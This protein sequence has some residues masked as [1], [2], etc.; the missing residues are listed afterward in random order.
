VPPAIAYRLLEYALWAYALLLPL[1][2]LYF[3]PA[4][5]SRLQLTEL[6]FLLAA[7]LALWVYR[8]RLLTALASPPVVALL[9]YLFVLSLATFSGASPA[10]YP[11]LLGRFYLLGVLLVFATYVADLGAPGQRKVI[12]AWTAGLY[13]MG[14]LAYLGY[15]LALAGYPTPLVSYY[16]NYP[17]FGTL[18]R[19]VGSAGGATAL[20]ALALL[21]LTVAYLRWR[22]TGARPWLLIFFAPLLLL[23]FSKEVLLLLLAL[24]LVE[25]LLQSRRGLR[26]VVVLSLSLLYLL[27]TH[28]LVEPVGDHSPRQS[29]RVYT[30]GR[31][32]WEGEHVRLVETSYTSLK[33]AAVSVAADHP[34]LGVGADGFP[35]Q[36]PRKKAEG[37]YPAHL[38]DYIPHSTWFGTL[39]ETGLLGLGTLLAFVLSLGR[40]LFANVR[41]PA[42]TALDHCL[43][44]YFSALLVGSLA[45]DLLHLRFF[46]VPVALAVGIVYR[47]TTA[48]AV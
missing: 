9:A 11:E 32:L 12:V 6:V 19:A 13:L 39:A 23:T 24:T 44:A 28:V 15:A 48:H 2:R 8:R 31:T 37:I 16:E 30:S 38:P 25:P 42:A 35:D 29:E 46:W 14:G 4:L 21:P 26:T 18:Y 27:T 20:V 17:Y 22:R 40:L 34:W 41:H 1:R 7:P 47:K 33:R 36:L 43:L 5:S 3:L 10:D 45:M